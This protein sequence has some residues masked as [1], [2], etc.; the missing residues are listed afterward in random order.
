MKLP[1]NLKICHIAYSDNCGGAARAA[2]RIHN[3]LVANQIENGIS[4][5]MRVVKK[6]STNNTVKG[7]P[8]FNNK[9]QYQFQ[10]NINRVARY[11]YSYIY[12]ESSVFSLAWP[13]TGLSKELNLEYEKNNL[14]IVNLHYLSENTLSVKEIGNLKMPLV[15]R[16]NDQ[17]PFC[18][19]EHYYE[20]DNLFDDEEYVTGYRKNK[21]FL[22]LKQIIW[23][24]K[25]NSW[26]RKIYI[27]APSNW[28]A[29]C[30]SKSY[31]FKN[32]PIQVIPSAIDLNFWRPVNKDKAR[33]K[34]NLP[35]NKK[36]L[37]FGAFEALSDFRKGGDLLL[38]SLAILSKKI[39]KELRENIELI[40]FGAIRSEVEIKTDFKLKYVGKINNDEILKLYYSASDVFVLPSRKD[41]LP[42]TGIE[43]HACGTPVVAFNVGG[44]PDIIDDKITGSLA[45][46]FEPESLAQEI[47]WVIENTE[48][49]NN[50][51]KAAREKAINIWDEK[52]ISKIY[53][54][55]YFEIY[56]DFYKI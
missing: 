22:D 25:K 39:S 23:L 13:S 33:Y 28:I 47:N 20:P 2:Y 54:D 48:R 38:K 19:S 18:S 12:P 17:W 34:L 45:E 10:K 1:N 21:K 49:N 27:I 6:F 56:K 5:K 16:L 40:I 24:N 42:G 30:A 14:D 52:R 9:I 4:S 32:Q 15:W 41:N 3:S 55:Y 44:L 43:S 37:L 26:K 31:L 7:G 46:P 35:M 29:K 53:S 8:A 11:I 50:L 36:L 51:K